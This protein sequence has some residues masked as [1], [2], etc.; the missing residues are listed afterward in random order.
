MTDANSN[1][2][3]L[4]ENLGAMQEQMKTTYGALAETMITGRSDDELVSIEMS[5]TYKL[6]EPGWLFDERALKGGLQAF[7]QRLSEAWEDLNQNIQST[8]QKQTMQLLQ[9]MPMP[10]GIKDMDS[11]LPNLQAEP[12]SGDK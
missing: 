5:A 9:S 1:I 12:I 8:T 2:E 11:L 7:K 3:Q 10:E 6:G 4:K